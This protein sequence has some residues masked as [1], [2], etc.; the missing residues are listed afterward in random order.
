MFCIG[1]MLTTCKFHHSWNRQP[2]REWKR[3]GRT[4]TGRQPFPSI[5]ITSQ[6]I[7]QP[8]LTAERGGFMLGRKMKGNARYPYADEWLVGQSKPQEW[9]GEFK[10]LDYKNEKVKG[11]GFSVVGNSTG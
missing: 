3:N 4:I 7:G 2:H 5:T 11:F 10:V 8:M 1:G 9:S 6:A